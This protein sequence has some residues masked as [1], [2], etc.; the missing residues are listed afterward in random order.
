MPDR[1]SRK[2]RVIFLDHGGVITDNDRRAAG[3]RRLVGEF[4]SPR[5][6]G[7]PRQWGDANSEVFGRQWQRFEEFVARRPIPG[8]HNFLETPIERERWLREMCEQVGVPAPDFDGCVALARETE[9]YVVPRI[10]ADYPGAAGAIRALHTDGYVL[11]TASGDPSSDLERH[12]SGMGVRECFTL[13]LYGPDLL[14]IF[15]HEQR[16]YEGIFA[17][18]KVN[19]AQAL[20]VDNDA[21]QLDLAAATGAHTVFVANDGAAPSETHTTIRALAELPTLLESPG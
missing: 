6:G 14:R 7:E 10:R 15:K 4:L 9:A 11:G 19:P 5:L 3:W 20:V 21:S 17:E 12:L 8:Y 13:P 18:T 2:P 1:L 16:Y